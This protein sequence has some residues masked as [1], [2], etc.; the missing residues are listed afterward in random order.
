MALMQSPSISYFDYNSTAPLSRSV[1]SYL[2]GLALDEWAN[3][4]SAHI[5]GSSA[6]SLLRECRQK[7]EDRL[8]VGEGRIIFTSGATE[9]IN[10][11]LSHGNLAS[12]GIRAIAVCSGDHSAA[13]QASRRLQSS[14]PVTF[15]GM[16]L[17]GEVNLEDLEKSLQNSS[18]TLV[19]LSWVNNEIGSI[20]DVC[21]V[22]KLVRRYGGYLHLDG[23]QAIGRTSVSI[24]DIDA[25]FISFSGHKF[26]ALKGCG[27]IYVRNASKF[28]P[29]LVGGRQEMGLRAGTVNLIAVRSVAMALD[30][31]DDLDIRSLEKFRDEIEGFILALSD[32]NRINGAKASARA[33]NTVNAFFDGK[34]ATTVVNQLSERSICISAGSA[35]LSGA[36]APS[37]VLMSMGFDKKYAASC[38]RISMG[39]DTDAY[40]VGRLKE[41]LAH[42]FAG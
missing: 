36:Y 3:T 6:S 27:F 7:I 4:E 31:L 18:P 29:F 8:G 37:Y 15:I 19:S 39:P 40:G 10:S 13:I 16:T 1:K 30:D 42:V 14:V 26:G 35:C 17:N 2:Q 9:S 23:A 12:L 22:A 38:V 5:L 25:D 24:S 34:N 33:P 21:Q 32:K 20:L 11:V 28:A 41:A